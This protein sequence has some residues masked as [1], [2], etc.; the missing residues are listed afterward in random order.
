MFAAIRPMYLFLYVN[1]VEWVDAQ[2]AVVKIKGDCD[3]ADG[4]A[5]A[6]NEELERLKEI[7]GQYPSNFIAIVYSP[8]HVLGAV[9]LSFC[10][11]TCWMGG[12][13]TM[14]VVEVPLTLV[15][16][17]V[18]DSDDSAMM[19][20]D[21]L[22]KCACVRA[23]HGSRVVMKMNLKE[24]EQIVKNDISWSDRAQDNLMHLLQKHKEN[25]KEFVD[26]CVPDE[27]A[28]F[29][30]NDVMLEPRSIRYSFFAHCCDNIQTFL[31][32]ESV[33]PMLD[34]LEVPEISAEK[35]AGLWRCLV[36]QFELLSYFLMPEGSG[37]LHLE[38]F[39]EERKSNAS[40]LK[41]FGIFRMEEN[42]LLCSLVDAC[43]RRAEVL[44]IADVLAVS[45]SQFETFFCAQIES[46]HCISNQVGKM[47]RIGVKTLMVGIDPST[48]NDFTMDEL[49]IKF[50]SRWGSDQLQVRGSLRL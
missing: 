43:L 18:L 24:Q 11:Y 20:A 38:E 27:V 32:E 15:L 47:L 42:T 41:V 36:R 22:I 14:P 29:F 8:E 26:L 10:G 7:K 4:D 45:F 5:D 6:N 35:D 13:K 33:I 37:M 21:I 1:G 39:I 30:V 44:E 46:R 34:N 31:C 48:M 19:L 23:L 16:P 9:E 17:P 3:A 28:L 2:I 40:P 12:E 25:I 49:E 50:F